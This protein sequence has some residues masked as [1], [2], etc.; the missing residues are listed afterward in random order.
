M[1]K[2][3]V[4]ITGLGPVSA[5]GTGKDEFWQGIV[6]GKSGVKLVQRIP[7]KLRPSCKIAAEMYDFDPSVYMDHKAVR[8]TDRFI[9]FAIAASKL[10]LTD[11]GL[12]LLCLR[13]MAIALAAPS[14]SVHGATISKASPVLPKP[15]IS[16]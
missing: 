8:R 11:S 1:T 14:P 16:A 9:Q 4:V 7:E 12:R 5:V 13:A 2:E 6:S 3:R 15:V 10:A